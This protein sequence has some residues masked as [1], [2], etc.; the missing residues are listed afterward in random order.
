[1]SGQT[2]GLWNGFLERRF[3]HWGF[4][5]V[6]VIGLRDNE[7]SAKDLAAIGIDPA[8]IFLTHDDALFCEKAGERQVAHERYLT[9]N[10]HFWGMKG[11]VRTEV[12][13]KLNRALALFRSKFGIEKTV[14]IPMHVSDLKSYR[15]Y[16]ELYP[17]SELEVLGGDGDFRRIRRAIADST[18]LLTMKH[19]PI[20][21]AVGEDTPV[22]SMAYSA[23]YVRKNFGAMQ[24]YGVESCSMDLAA[25]EWEL[26]L[27]RALDRARDV[28][29]FRQCVQQGRGE[30]AKRR[31]GFLKVVDSVIGARTAS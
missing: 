2:I 24:Q 22:V 10:F 6:A 13:A 3:A 16:Q 14:F 15:A 28:D 30:A 17:D 31:E 9:V 25:D 18:A 8:R 19:H 23:Y 1:M 21:F 27:E 11:A 29:W 5:D 7:A 4:R 12:L 20:I 26:D